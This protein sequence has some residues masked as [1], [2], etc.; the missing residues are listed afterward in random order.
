[1]L[2]SSK[3][4]ELVV[5]KEFELWMQLGVSLY[6]SVEYHWADLLVSS[7]S[8][9]LVSLLCTSPVVGLIQLER[10]TNPDFHLYLLVSGYR[11]LS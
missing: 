6:V 5:V 3:N 11:I 7:W 9:L 10:R 2:D 8:A 4:S 1:M